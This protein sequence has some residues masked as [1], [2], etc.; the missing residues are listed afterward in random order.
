MGFDAS[1]WVGIGSED[2]L[3][4]TAFVVVDSSADM[5]LLVD[6]SCLSASFFLC[7][8]FFFLLLDWGGTEAAGALLLEDTPLELDDSAVRLS[9][10]QIS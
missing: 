6:D 7:F 3:L 4:E 9:L 8:F 5:A 2:E 10:F 1:G